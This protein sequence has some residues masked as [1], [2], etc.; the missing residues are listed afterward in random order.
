M[1]PIIFPYSLL[2][3]SK[4]LCGGSTTS[5][6]LT[7]ALAPGVLVLLDSIMKA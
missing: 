6:L 1:H 4:F 2:R 5:V 7:A 3:A